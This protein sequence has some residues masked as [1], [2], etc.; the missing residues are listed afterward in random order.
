MSAPMWLAELGHERLAEAHDLQRR[1][2]PFGSK[3]AAALAAAHGQRGQA[4]LEDLLEAQE[5]DDAQVYGRMQAQ[6]A[7]V[8][9][10]AAVE[11]HAEAAVYLDLAFVVHPRNAEHDHALGLNDALE[12]TC[13]LVLGMRVDDRLQRREHLGYGLDELGLVWRSWPLTCSMTE[14][15]VAHGTSFVETQRV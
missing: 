4:V 6:A 2:L 8:G 7:L 11:L 12:Q 1:D 5:L 14:F 13:R 10:K 15:N 9:P 3:S